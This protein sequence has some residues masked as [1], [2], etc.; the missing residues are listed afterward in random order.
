MNEQE[1]PRYFNPT[2]SFDGVAVIIALLTCCI[3]F[4]KL[5]EKVSRLDEA[6]KHH[7]E[8]LTEL[9]H[10]TDVMQTL[11]SERTRPK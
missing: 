2:I 3:W 6:S 7:E 1:K 4:G 10:N 11:I 9:R 5:S 8:M